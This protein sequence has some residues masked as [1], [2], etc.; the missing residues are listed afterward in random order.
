MTSPEGDFLVWV[1]DAK[2]ETVGARTVTLGKTGP[3]GVKVLQGL[4]QGEVIVTAGVQH[5][6]AGARIRPIAP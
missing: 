1:M 4:T 3:L 6:R 2:T 5:L